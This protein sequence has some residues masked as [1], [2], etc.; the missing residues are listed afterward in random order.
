LQPAEGVTENVALVTGL[1]ALGAVRV[2]EVLVKATVSPAP[3]DAGKPIT[4][5]AAPASA[6][7][8]VTV[9][10]PT[11]TAPVVSLQV[12]ATLGV[13]VNFGKVIVSV[14]NEVASLVALT[15]AVN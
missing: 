6:A 12:T 11:V 1:L 10:V 7:N 4:V 15:P 2:S 8:G 3:G 5:V 13:T 14:T 9:M